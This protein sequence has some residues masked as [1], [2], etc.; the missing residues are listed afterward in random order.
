L[1]AAELKRARLRLGLT[2]VELAKV[3]NVTSA[4]V[5]RWERGEHKIPGAVALALPT[6]TPRTAASL[7]QRTK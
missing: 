6:L 7:R 3:L 2:Q 1:K 4:T 5:S